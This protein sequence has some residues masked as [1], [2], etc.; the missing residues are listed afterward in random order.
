MRAFEKPFPRIGMV[1]RTLLS[2]GN[3]FVPSPLQI[4][5]VDDSS[6]D[7]MLAIHEIKKHFPDAV[8]LE[9]GTETELVQQLA[10]GGFDI[11]VTDYHL[12]WTDGLAVFRR[13]RDLYPACPVILYTGTGNE[14]LAE[15]ALQAGLDDFVRKADRRQVFLVK[16]IRQALEQ[17]NQRAQKQAAE[18]RYRDLFN[19]LPL[20]I[21]VVGV[22][23]KLLDANSVMASM[24][25]FPDRESLLACGLYPLLVSDTMQAEFLRRLK[26]DREVCGLEV[27]VRRRDDSQFWARM[28]VH[29]LPDQEGNSGS[30]EAIIEDIQVTRD[31]AVMHQQ[32]E[33]A[34]RESEYRYRTLAEAAHDMIFIISPGFVVEYA[35]SFAC[36][37][38]GLQVSQVIGKLL[39]D[40]F[41]QPVLQR[42]K[43]SLRIEFETGI[44]QYFESSIPF[45]T[46]QLW[47]GTWLAPIHGESGRIQSVLGVSRDITIAKMAERR[48][49]N[50]EEAYRSLVETSPDGIL[51]RGPEATITFANPRM[52][53]MLGVPALAAILGKDF[54]DLLAPEE[55]ERLKSNMEIL[56]HTGSIR[57]IQYTLRRSN[58]ATLPIEIS[59]TISRDPIGN[60]QGITS[61][62]RDVSARAEQERIR[63]ESEARF[64]VVFEESAMGTAV[65][66]PEGEILDVNSALTEILG[67]SR[68]ALI[69]TDIRELLL[70][71][72]DEDREVLHQH[73]HNPFANP[74]RAQMP[75]RRFAGPTVWCRLT[76]SS[77][78][79]KE[80]KMLYSIGLIEDVSKQ[81]ETE[82]TLRQTGAAIQQY[83]ERLATLHE[84]D[85]AI[86]E[87]RSLDEIA[88]ATLAQIGELIPNQRS[89][90]LLFN[91]KKQHATFLDV[92]STLGHPYSKGS[93]IPFANLG[94]DIELLRRGELFAIDDLLALEN[95][96]EM[97]R[98]M[99]IEGIR[100][101]LALPM[102]SRGELIGSLNFA[103]AIPSY[104]RRE[105]ADIAA[106]VANLLAVAITDA[107]LFEQVQQHSAELEAIAALNVEL[108]TPMPRLEITGIVLRRLMDLFACDSAAMLEF[109]SEQATFAVAQ[110]FGLFAAATGNTLL[111]PD[112]ALRSLLQSNRPK[113]QNHVNERPTAAHIGFLSPPQTIRGIAYIPLSTRGQPMGMLCIAHTQIR[114]TG[115]REF[116]DSDLPMLISVG[117]VAAGALHRAALLEQ[118]DQR[119]RRLSALHV[120]DM[121]I[122][123]S[124]D[125]RVTLSVLLDQITT[126]LKVQAADVLLL[127]PH[128]QLLSWAAGRGFR[129]SAASQIQLRL[130]QGLAGLAALDRRVV[131]VPHLEAHSELVTAAPREETTGF[132]S[133][134]AAP[135]ISKGQVKGVLEI[136]S[137][138][139]LDPDPEWV[140]YLETMANQAAIAVENATLFEDLQRTNTDLVA[141]YDATIE[142]W[143]RALELHDQEPV[144]HTLRVA[145]TTV[146]FARAIGVRD[147]ELIHIRRGALIHDIGKMAVPDYILQ[148]EG[149]LT[150]EELAIVRR[151]PTFAFE[152]L[153]PINYLRP[154]LDIPY[155]HHEQWDGGGYPHGLKGDQIPLPARL[156]AIVDVWD[157]LRNHRPHRK[158]WPEERVRHFLRSQSG[159]HFDPQALDVFFRLLEEEDE[160]SAR[161]LT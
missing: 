91:Y 52:L 76:L 39:D 7:R 38:F 30:F 35:N 148:K 11:V 109:N 20:G 72:T 120:V 60:L 29:A 78:S 84:I 12:Q 156:F 127:N 93:S 9:A 142:G 124:I 99:L 67:F 22:G 74:F 31:E 59:S 80:G 40:L 87:A 140:E 47:L 70:P 66:D 116:A 123:A 89:S 32:Q 45:A 141:A 17:T 36:Q 82:Q 92:H 114:D 90:V 58:G 18:T 65:I 48:L 55:V 24:L 27:E 53:E 46:Q 122:S 145:E 129:S 111:D 100:S 131:S 4:L 68:E 126:Q 110:S 2:K 81:M 34:L 13:I 86:Q 107:R 28:S 112:S 50:S 159:R 75:L 71:E 73:I 104:F 3:T 95:P 151:H 23:G 85:K 37:S 33:N 69:Q 154:A 63:Q 88:S 96:T 97:D 10:Q 147:T 125:L 101:F 136:F 132:T 57:N 64:H 153:S 16:A 115:G 160:N 62:I 44:P 14:I 117:D 144:G 49:Q 79:D 128:T 139:P 137:R 21:L 103:S 105:H 149:V 155:Y 143:S 56:L 161:S 157:A 108:R 135:L 15:T 8:F 51:M 158:A 138:E 118:T 119:L 26:E 61:I 54:S 94:L 113:Y 98:R 83:A 133:Y 152:L 146:M 150:E 19:S 42:L 102:I 106:E 6:D 25:G 77:V 134:Y 121:A 130:G 43:A 41:P 5:L 1:A